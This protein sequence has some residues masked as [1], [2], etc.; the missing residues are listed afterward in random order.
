MSAFFL[1]TTGIIAHTETNA[2]PEPVLRLISVLFATGEQ[3]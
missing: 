3:L 2:R 1:A